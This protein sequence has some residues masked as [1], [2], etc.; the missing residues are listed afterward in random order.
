MAKLDEFEAYVRRTSCGLFGMAARVIDA[1]FAAD[2][3][4]DAAGLAYG[5]S[6]LVAAVGAH[7]ARGR[8][9]VP[10]D[11]L[12]RHGV[13]PDDVLAGR[14]SPAVAAALSD[15]I[16]GAERQYE[17]FF[18]LAKRMPAPAR[19]AF[20]PV[21]TV[22]LALR[23]LRARE[24]YAKQ[25]VDLSPLRRLRALLRAALFGFPKP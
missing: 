14:S 11:V 10:A 13:G 8:V 4:A 20:L 22:P 15:L 23:R 6:A 19:A 24:D 12:A 1:T 21:A 18:A 2:E 16:L 3:A 17:T 7:A 9:Y 25:I 5:I